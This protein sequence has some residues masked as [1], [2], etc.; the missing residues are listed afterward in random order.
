MKDLAY[1]LEQAQYKYPSSQFLLSIDRLEIESGRIIA[2][3]GPNGAGK[4]T[5][6]MLLALLQKPCSGSL[7]F[8]GQKPW[9]GSENILRFRRDVVMVTHHPYLF[10]G[11]VFDN[12]VFGLKVRGVDEEA[13]E[14]R[15]GEALALVELHGLENQSVSQLS[16]GQAQRVALARAIILRPKVMLLDE[17][18]ANIDPGMSVRIESLIRE[19]NSKLSTTIV[20]STHNFSQA[21][22]LANEIMYFSD[23]R[24]VGYGHEN[25]FSGKAETD[26]KISW[27]EPRPGAKIVFSGK[28]NGFATVAISPQ[29]IEIFSKDDGL[30]TGDPNQFWG[31]VTGLEVAGDN[32]C[33]IR[34]SGPLNFLINVPIEEINKKNIALSRQILVRFPPDV[35]E[36]LK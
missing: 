21:F 30:K 36:L 13:W 34:F 29:K 17:P 25:Y 14:P 4:T 16:A 27:I 3:A 33:I 10:R 18:T 7:A 9:D 6:L 32:H 5:L 28:I 2:L 8:F 11:T 12:L 31:T 23:G 15:V 26:G 19:I 20:F 35:V 1:I 22:R 24:R